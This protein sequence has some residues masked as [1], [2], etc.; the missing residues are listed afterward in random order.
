MIPQRG[1][2]EAA[3]GFAVISRRTRGGW[4][5]VRTPE[6]NAESAVNPAAAER[7]EDYRYLQNLKRNHSHLSPPR[8]PPFPPPARTCYAPLPHMTLPAILFW[9]CLLGV[10]YIYAGYP[11]LIGLLARLR[12]R[13]VAKADNS[14][15]ISVIISI[16]NEA[17]RL[18][19]KIRSLLN[20]PQ[21]HRINEILIGNDAGHDDPQAALHDLH[22]PRIRLISFP[23][24]RGKPSVLN[25]LIPL[26]TGDLLIM[27]DVRQRL[28]PQALTHLLANFSDPTIGV[29]SGELIFEAADTDTSAAAGIDTYWRYE[30]WIRDREGRF[31]SVPGATG[32][33]YAMRRELAQPLPPHAALDDVLLPMRAIASR[34]RCTFEPAA[35][36]YD[37][38][39]QDPAREAIRKR[40]TLAGCVQLLRFHPA[41]IFP[42]GHPIWWQFASHKIA[43]LFSPF[44]LLGALL[45]NLLLLPL[46]PIYPILLAIHLLAL[47][48]GTYGWLRPT[49]RGRLAGL[50][51]MFLAMQATLLRAWQ[52]GLTQ[53]NLARWDKA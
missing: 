3:V 31:A 2:S 48:I 41:W 51:A 21:A 11:L 13:P 46:H 26:A 12:P 39:A 43:R 35:K 52:D 44:L 5:H 17:P 19:P 32:A 47:A 8:R 4:T 37:R 30:K 6:F 29:V 38:P 34:Y 15:T 10:G 27:M 49:H 16:Y 36:I 28:D 14:L 1:I 24:R 33:L 18:A 40:R 23:E 50:L 45:L 25:D 20:D 42:G 22:D 53:P 7:P 9:F